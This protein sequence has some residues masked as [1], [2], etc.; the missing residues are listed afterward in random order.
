MD[1]E[2]LTRIHD[3]LTAGTRIEIDGE[4]VEFEVVQRT[5]LVEEE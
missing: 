5:V 3:E 1:K 4:F 2:T